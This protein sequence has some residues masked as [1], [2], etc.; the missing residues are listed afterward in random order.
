MSVA[1]ARRVFDI[2]DVEN[3]EHGDR[4][5]AI[6]PRF[7]RSLEFRNVSFRYDGSR[8]MALTGIELTVQAGEVVAFV[9][10]SGSGKST[11]VHLVLRFYNP[12]GGAILIDG[13]DIRQVT[14]QSL[15][16]QIGVVP[17]DPILFDDT[18]R[19]NISYGRIGAGDAE[20]AAAAKAAGAHEFIERLPN[21]YE[22][23]IGE[24]GVRLSGGQRQRL[25][26]ARAVLRDSP[27]LILD[28]ATSSLDSESERIVQWALNNFMKQRTTLVIAH[29][30]ST[31]LNAHRI[32]VLDRG[33]LAG[34]GTHE[35]LLGSC[36]VYQRLYRAQFQELGVRPVRG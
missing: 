17:Q 19:N 24:K 18:V 30:L 35:Q 12:L 13:Q 5:K 36:E 31:V 11:L 2:L 6:L 15:R 4:G 33:R 20:I 3:E 28:E 29:R 16:R 14:L 22:T 10:S 25:A 32:V 9:G 27:I 7:S 1:A 8:E 34:S 26:I 21:G 23:I